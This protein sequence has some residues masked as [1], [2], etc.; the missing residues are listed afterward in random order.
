M[1]WNNTFT[2]QR[3]INS[4]ILKNPK[5]LFFVPLPPPVHGAA[6]RNKA[7]VESDVLNKAFD[8]ILIPF[9]FAGNLS[10]IGKFSIK[11]LIR[12]ISRAY[13]IAFKM[14]TIKPD[15]VY[16]NFSVYG[17]ALYRD[18]FFIQ[19]FKIFKSKI[20]LH[21]RTQGV[22]A[23]VTSSNF[24]LWLFRKTFKGSTVICLSKQLS[25]DIED[26]YDLPPKIVCNGIEDVY[27]KYKKN[28][29]NT[30]KTI[31]FVSNLSRRKGVLELIEALQI[32]K[33]NSINFSC[34]I[35]GDE[36]D[37]KFEQIEE[38]LLANSLTKEVSLLG[39]K[40]EHEKYGLLADANIFVLPTHFEAFPGVIL[41]A[42]QFEIPVVSTFEGAIPEII[43]DGVTGLLVKKQD[44]IDLAA[45]LTTLLEDRQLREILGKNGRIKFV[46]QYTLRS[47]EENMIKTFDEILKG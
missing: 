26:V 33:S 9:N 2:S 27:Y 17:L 15:I 22:Q 41:E 24:K 31:L 32:I 28:N 47:F 11:K 7:L 13:T 45:K 1:K 39:P 3:V 37:L 34:L 25:K 10:D 43:D 6:L 36:W 29:R 20:I 35:V 40:Y 4:N 14:I 16:F 38:L 8:I 18:F 42:M 5:I 30:N 44:A 12:M 21:L 46:D 19:L 23:Q